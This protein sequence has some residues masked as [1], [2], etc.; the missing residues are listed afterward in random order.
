MCPR[1]PSLTR[2]LSPVTTGGAHDKHVVCLALIKC[3]RHYAAVWYLSEIND[4][5]AAYVLKNWPYLVVV[6][7]A[8]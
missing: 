3:K 4:Y 7:H 6:A 5:D 8:S 2:D 1:R